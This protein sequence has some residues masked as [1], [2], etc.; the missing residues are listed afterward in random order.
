[1]RSGPAAAPENRSPRELP[2]LRTFRRGAPRRMRRPCGR[3]GG[4]RMRCW[5]RPDQASLLSPCLQP[6]REHDRMR[7]LETRA[8]RSSL[9]TSIDGLDIECSRGPAAAI[10][11]PRFLRRPEVT[12]RD[13]REGRDV[14]EARTARNLERFRIVRTPSA[15]WA[16]RAKAIV[17]GIICAPFPDVSEYV[18]QTEC[19]RPCRSVDGLVG[20]RSEATK[21]LQRGRGVA[22]PPWS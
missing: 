4:P 6:S 15:R 21:R 5:S 17:L 3:R 13:A 18:N 9:T 12:Q 7:V 2:R 8:S 1:M 19:V 20:W 22:G 10:V 14:E 11:E 16:G